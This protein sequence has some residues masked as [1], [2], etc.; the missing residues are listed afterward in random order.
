MSHVPHSDRCCCT[1]LR[2]KRVGSRVKQ[3][4]SLRKAAEHTRT[5]GRKAILKSSHTPGLLF[6]WLQVR[7]SSLASHLC[8][9]I[10][11]QWILTHREIYFFNPNL[12]PDC[13]VQFSYWNKSLG[14]EARTHSG[15]SSYWLAFQQLSE[16]AA[17][18]TLTH[19]SSNVPVSLTVALH[20]LDAL[21]LP[22]WGQAPC[23]HL[24]GSAHLYLCSH[25]PAPMP[26][27][28]FIF[29]TTVIISF[30]PGSTFSCLSPRYLPHKGPSHRVK[31]TWIL[32]DM[33]ALMWCLTQF[34]SYCK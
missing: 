28:F 33:F 19:C 29:V 16:T 6:S 1:R 7:H 12:S 18:Q 2:P 32:A 20:C 24:P 13:P 4:N 5:R 31:I 25:L 17:T 23:L 14:L 15:A 9:A 26:T 10:R 34:C 3:L 30:H 8:C 22:H 11:L 27:G 21:L